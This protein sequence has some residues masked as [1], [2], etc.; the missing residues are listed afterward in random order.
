MTEGS[1]QVRFTAAP[2]LS[3]HSARRAGCRTVTFPGAA[4]GFR[5]NGS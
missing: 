5:R 2:S 4:G 3:H 1:I